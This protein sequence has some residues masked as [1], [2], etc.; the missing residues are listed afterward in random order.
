MPNQL[1]WNK[2][3]TLVTK[4]HSFHAGM[5]ICWSMLSEI[6]E[7]IP[8]NFISL[9]VTDP[10]FTDP[11]LQKGNFCQKQNNKKMAFRYVRQ[12][13]GCKYTRKTIIFVSYM[14]ILY[15]PNNVLYSFIMMQICVNECFFSQQAVELFCK[16]QQIQTNT[17]RK[18]MLLIYCY[19]TKEL[20]YH[21]YLWI[22]PFF[23]FVSQ[24]RTYI[25]PQV[26]STLF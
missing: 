8:I 13:G 24:N 19:W 10:G 18:Q 6:K 22:C 7:C 1:S 16:S 12:R 2:W 15:T 26:F 14:L 5:W 17:M 9:R 11:L 3:E 21:S 25:L 20:V 4:N 23:F